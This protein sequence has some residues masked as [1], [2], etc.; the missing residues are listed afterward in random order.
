M[1]L[2]NK[3][4]WHNYQTLHTSTL[5]IFSLEKNKTKTKLKTPNPGKLKVLKQSI[6]K[7]VIKKLAP[8]RF[9]LF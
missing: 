7:V 5:K 6:I 4:A 3:V 1:T 2:A 9:G 8:V